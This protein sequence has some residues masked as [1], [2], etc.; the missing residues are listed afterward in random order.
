M[1]KTPAV[2]T[3]A[4]HK[5]RPGKTGIV[6]GWGLLTEHPTPTPTPTPSV[7]SLCLCALL[8]ALKVI[9]QNPESGARVL[10]GL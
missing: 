4:E 1:L 6:L 9:F 2:T 10:R 8:P 3:S 5:P 7:V